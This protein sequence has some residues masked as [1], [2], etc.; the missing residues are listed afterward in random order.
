M[1]RNPNDRFI[2]FSEAPLSLQY[3]QTALETVKIPTVVLS[4]HAKGKARRESVDKFEMSSSGYRGLLLELK[5][6]ARGLWVT[7]MPAGA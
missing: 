5:H 2:I 1:M 6:G 4:A 7:S 3:L